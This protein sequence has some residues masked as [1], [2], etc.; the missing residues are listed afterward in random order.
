M[1]ESLKIK[2][3]I[4]E[5]KNK[6]SYDTSQLVETKV[7]H[8]WIIWLLENGLCQD[9][10]QP[11]F[12]HPSIY[13]GCKCGYFGKTILSKRTSN[14]RICHVCYCNKCDADG[15][16]LPHVV[17]KDKEIVGEFEMYFG[18]YKGVSIKEIYDLDKKYL[19]W[20]LENV[21]N[22]HQKLKDKIQI[23]LEP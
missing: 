2:S 13:D 23:F 22:K 18:K 17:T 1:S 16:M 12:N 7:G 4:S 11:K 21:D 10:S 3:I 20:I 15:Y 6:G 19:N 9:E 14:G 8:I 5:F